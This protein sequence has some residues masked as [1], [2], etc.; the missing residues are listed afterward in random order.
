MEIICYVDTSTNEHKY[1]VADDA[2]IFA[3]TLKPGEII[4]YVFNE[5]ANIIARNDRYEQGFYDYCSDYNLDPKDLHGT[6]S[7]DGTNPDYELVGLNPRNN[8]YKF[9]LKNIST[10]CLTKATH[11]FFKNLIKIA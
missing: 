3:K 4:K 1:T 2:S 9:I 8:K 5:S 6:Y 7:K 11:G 10:G